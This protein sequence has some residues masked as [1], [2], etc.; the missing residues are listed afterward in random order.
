MKEEFRWVVG[1]KGSYKI[2]NLGRVLSVERIDKCNHRR[3]E[4]FLL[5]RVNKF[6]YEIVEL[7]KNSKH[8]Q[9]KVH[10]LVAEA[11][12]PNPEHKPCIDHINAIKNDNRV[13]NLRWVT[14]KENMNNPLTYDKMSKNGKKN[15]N[16]GCKSPF[17]RKIGQYLLNGELIE[18]FESAGRASDATGLGYSAIRKCANGKMPTC[19]G[20]IWKY[21]TEAVIKP[22]WGRK[23]GFGGIP[24]IQKSIDGIFIKEYKSIGCAASENGFFQENIGRAIKNNKPYN[25]YI[26]SIKE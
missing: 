12:I 18:V 19:G 24:V 14:H 6:G 15:A 26:W 20:F 9:K 13:E 16:Y 21:I 22:K 10:R 1:F 2:S 5:P 23:K 7:Y 25:G 8:Y 4:H 17:S 3:H 11:F